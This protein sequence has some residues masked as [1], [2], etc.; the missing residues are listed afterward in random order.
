MLPIKIETLP[1][2][3]TSS[4]TW[5]LIEK[6]LAAIAELERQN[7]D[8]Y[9]YEKVAYNAIAYARYQASK[10]QWLSL[11]QYLLDRQ[12]LQIGGIAMPPKNRIKP[13]AKERNKTL[14]PSSSKVL[15]KV[16]E[17]EAKCKR[18]RN[19]ERKTDRK[20]PTYLY[21]FVSLKP[22]L[23]GLRSALTLWRFFAYSAPLC[24]RLKPPL[25]DRP[26]GQRIKALLSY[27]ASGGN[28]ASLKVYIPSLKKRYRMNPEVQKLLLDWS[29]P[30]R[31]RT[32]KKVES[33]KAKGLAKRVITTDQIREILTDKW[34]DAV[35]IASK[36]NELLGENIE[37]R[38]ISKLLY[39]RSVAGEIFRFNRD[40]HEISYFS[41]IEATEFE[42]EWMTL[43]MA[44]QLAITRGCKSARNTFR[45]THK[46]DYSV[47]GIGFRKAAPSNECSLLRY[48]DISNNI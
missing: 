12:V 16:L 5:A 17:T 36:L 15:E 7:E 24:S 35:A 47:F 20:S 11:W 27:K 48:R 30:Q 3:E 25:C 45:K 4:Q 1:D 8:L 22:C 14:K 34:Q 26:D 41:R 42:S 33:D 21:E 40:H 28:Y 19:Y 37:L 13:E 18:T 43:E 46:F 6:R 32:R 10:K 2:A 38:K 29:N 39:N 9:P 31:T 23:S 44:Y